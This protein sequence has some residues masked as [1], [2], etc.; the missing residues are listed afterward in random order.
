MAQLPKEQP[1]RRVALWRELREAG[2]VPV[3]AGTWGTPA[4][5]AFPSAIGWAREICARG[6]GRLAVFN[7]SPGKEESTA[8]RLTGLVVMISID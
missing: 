1:H 7:A 3:S 8:M 6:G 2:A 4:G 5:P